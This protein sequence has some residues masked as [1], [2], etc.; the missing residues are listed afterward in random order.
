[1]EPSRQIG[2]YQ[3]N[4]LNYRAIEIIPGKDCNCALSKHAGKRMLYSEVL[5]LSTSL[6]STCSCTFKHYKDRRHISERRKFGIESLTSNPHGRIRA[7]GRRVVDIHN[8]A[9]DHFAKVRMEATLTALQ[10]A[11]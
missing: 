3:M 2:D 6:L 10:Q 8:R 11:G 9:R 1:M 7:Y 4:S 5:E